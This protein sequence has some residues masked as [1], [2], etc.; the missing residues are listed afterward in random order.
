MSKKLLHDIEQLKQKLYQLRPFDQFQLQNIKQRFRIA[1]IQNSNAIE[2]NTMTLSEVKVLL[3]DGITVWWK[4]IKELRETLN[5][6][7]VIDTL[8]GFFNL[9]KIE[10]EKALLSLHST[11][12]QWCLDPIHIG[13][14]R[15]IQVEISWSPD[16]CPNP[17]Q[18]PALMDAFL[19]SSFMDPKNEED[20]AR[21]HYDFVKIHPFVD[22]NGR[23]A[24]LLMNAWLVHL[25]YFPIIIPVVLRNEYISSL[26]GDNF[27]K[28]YEFFLRQLHENLKDTVRF[29]SNL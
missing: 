29:F 7:E 28:R 2:W 21:L 15:T 6:A 26:R 3:E 11:L 22:G 13:K 23:I 9:D 4:T 16:S 10:K 8:Y 17:S 18:I 20:I 27:V 25:W 12:L 14:R 24:R 1:Y 19:G 5:H